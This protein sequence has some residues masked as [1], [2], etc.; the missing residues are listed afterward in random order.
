MARS[1]GSAKSP[2]I[3]ALLLLV[4]SLTGSLLGQLLGAHMPFLRTMESKI[5]LA[6]QVLRLADV[7]HLTF[8]FTFSLNIATVLGM[9]LAIWVYRKL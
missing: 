5:A 1:G 3:L 7:L 9:G 6:P 4:G 8:G 2:W